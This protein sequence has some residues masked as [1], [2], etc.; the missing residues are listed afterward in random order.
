[1]DIDNDKILLALRNRH[2]GDSWAYFNELRT[3]TGYRGHIGYIDAYAVG[4]WAENKSF[5]AYEVKISR[6]DF[7]SDIENF[8]SK[9][10]A[11]LRNSTQF[12]YVCPHGLI[13]PEEVPEVAGLMF[14][15]AGGAKVKKVAPI[16]ELKNGGLEE[17][18]TMALLRA[19]A[20]KPIQRTKA[21]KYLGKDMT[22]D[23]LLDVAKDAGYHKDA[24]DIRY[25]VR[26]EVAKK[27]LRAYH[28]L[29]KFCMA[30]GISADIDYDT[31]ESQVDRLDRAF[32][33]KQKEQDAC[34][35]ILHN[36]QNITLCAE[37]LKK[38]VSEPPG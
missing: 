36:I 9:Q 11:A 16:R 13:Q 22:E 5:I 1:V 10:S 4:L 2:T 26:Q 21:W 33:I 27:R 37:E 30:V 24:R 29:N 3:K 38:L 15:D 28:I 6:A 23:E 34:R 17:T 14:I 7:K 18:F 35:S 32:H 19:A 25:M 20:E 12:Y 31:I 8:A